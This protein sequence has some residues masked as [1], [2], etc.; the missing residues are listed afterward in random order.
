M[1]YATKLAL[2][3]AQLA[4]VQAELWEVQ[5]SQ[6]PDS[7]RMKYSDVYAL[8]FENPKDLEKELV[9]WDEHYGTLYNTQIEELKARADKAQD[10][11][12]HHKLAL[13]RSINLALQSPQGFFYRCGKREDG[14]Y[15]WVG[16]RYG[17]EPEE[18]MS[19][20]TL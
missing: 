7:V 14:T 6:Y 3:E 20:F 9:F 1:H 12:M 18:Y 17:V 4:E 8:T 16:Y 15:K 19:G 5:L 2:F 11:V 10:L 13:S